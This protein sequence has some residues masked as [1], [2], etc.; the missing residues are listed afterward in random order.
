[1]SAPLSEAD[2]ALLADWLE[3]DHEAVVACA[4]RSD[5]IAAAQVQQALHLVL[6]ARFSG[7]APA[8]VAHRARALAWTAASRRMRARQIVARTQRTRRSSWGLAAAALVMLSVGASVAWPRLAAVG[9]VTGMDAVLVRN[10]HES[11]AAGQALRPGDVVVAD[12]AAARLSLRDGTTLDLAPGGRVRLVA[13]QA[14]AWGEAKLIELPVG[15]LTCAVAPQP[16]GAPLEV[17]TPLATVTVVGTRFVLS[18]QANGTDLAVHEGRVRFAAATGASLEVAADGLACVTA[19]G[20]LKPAPLAGSAAEAL[21]GHWR[22]D[23]TAGTR[24]VDS[25][26][27]GH[28][29]VLQGGA[30]WGP[31]RVGGALVLDGE[32]GFAQIPHAADLAVEAAAG[33]FTLALWIQTIH[34]RPIL[35]KGRPSGHLVSMPWV[36]F[37]GWTGQPGLDAWCWWEDPSPANRDRAS[38]WQVPVP[39]LYD[40]RWHHIALVNAAV[41]LRQMYV[42]GVLLAT[43]VRPWPADCGNDEPL[44]VGRYANPVAHRARY[45]SGSIDDLRLYRR[46]LGSR[47]VTV[48]AHPE[49]D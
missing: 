47:E 48:L 39:G 28:D 26:G 14:W 41:D 38:Q 27:R 17:I 6:R 24:A 36:L 3:G 43:D 42:D 8:V 15:E 5:L 46:A 34:A 11:D 23:E 21:V 18:S 7:P 37:A 40:G 9:T 29:G 32:T 31:G 33:P 20:R 16:A 4:Q 13:A 30:G 12:R 10:H 35:A 25:S 19:A 45:F 44:D 1:M 49:S 2:A 22:F